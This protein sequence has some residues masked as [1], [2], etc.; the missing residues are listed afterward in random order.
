MPSPGGTAENPDRQALLAEIAGCLQ[1]SGGPGPARKS[2]GAV[3]TPAVLAAFV[4]ERALAFL[5][6]GPG[7]RST[8]H[9]LPRVL[10]PACGSGH[11]L[12]AAWS[13]IRGRWSGGPAPVAMLAGLDSDPVAVAR[14]A[15]VLELCARLDEIDFGCPPTVPALGVG[16]AL[17]DDPPQA[18]CDL[19]VGNPP[20]VRVDRLAPAYRQRLRAK[21]GDVLQGKWDLY[22]CFLASWERWLAPDG[23]LAFV[24]PNQYLLGNSAAKLRRE[25]SQRLR[26]RLLLDCCGLASFSGAIPPAAIT[27]FENVVPRADDRIQAGIGLPGSPGPSSLA[28]LRCDA[29][30]GEVRQDLWQK[31]RWSVFAPE[32]FMAWLGGLDAPTLGDL[33]DK[34]GEGDTQRREE[35]LIAPVERAPSDWQ[36]AIRGRNIAAGRILA[37][38]D[39]LPPVPTAT[40]GRV[41]IRDVAARL[42][43]APEL[44]PVRCLRTVYCA[45]PR[46]RTLAGPIAALLNTDL[47]TWIYLRLFYSSKMSPQ[48]ANF[49]F[50]AQFL[51]HL[52]VVF[53]AGPPDPDRLGDRALEAYR[54]PRCY[55]DEI[56][57]LLARLGAGPSQGRQTALGP[58]ES[59]PGRITRAP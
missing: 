8:G 30:W 9:R 4:V 40:P 45:Y 23:I 43:A 38:G 20:Y 57:A 39:R 31:G 51:R 34:I 49:R 18:A 42:V 54:V 55:R 1:V 3:Y 52:P 10:D 46:D 5:G 28:S 17:L 50:Q 12:V 6:D 56:P 16:D 13:A 53:P 48:A 59:A 25:L 26:I 15:R 2:Q 27:I 21:Y 32:P 22:L 19:V 33:C 29:E 44:A 35:A 24:T 37:S 41:L 58:L 47:L 11:F 14:C 36:P 7:A